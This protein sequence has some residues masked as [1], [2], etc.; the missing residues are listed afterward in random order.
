MPMHHI[1][2]CGLP[3]IQYFP[4]YLTIGTILE[5]ILLSKNCGFWF[6]LQLSSKTFHILRWNERDVIK[7]Y[8]GFHVKNHLV[9]SIIMKLELSCQVWKIHKYQ[10]LWKSVPWE[11]ICSMGAKRRTDMTKLTV[12]FRNFAKAPNNSYSPSVML[13]L[14][15]CNSFV[16]AADSSCLCT[17]SGLW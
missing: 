10:I 12:A 1:V 8:I 11:Q 6:S 17:V 16:C 4:H 13:I 5:I 14:C 7:M 15:S 3:A 2:I 9:N